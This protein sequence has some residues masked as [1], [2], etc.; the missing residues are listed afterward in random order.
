MNIDTDQLLNIVNSGKGYDE[1]TAEWRPNAVKA[2]QSRL[3]VETL[4]H[5]LGLE[6]SD[7]ELEQEFKTLSEE[8][9]AP[10]EEVKKYY[11]QE[12]MKEYLKEDIRERKLFDKFLAE[13]TFKKGKKQKYLDL[14]TN[15]G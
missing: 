5:D 6:A 7:E 9:N 12:N 2:L 14:V 8:A 11:E 10:V 4:I 3:I 13:N 15:N 1:L